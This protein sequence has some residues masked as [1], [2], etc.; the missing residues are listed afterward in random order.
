MAGYMV[1]GGREE[2][3]DH[4]V[5]MEESGSVECRQQ[6]KELMEVSPSWYSGKEGHGD[7]QLEVPGTSS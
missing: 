6:D 5:M 4:M 3:G 7:A 1:Q 2:V